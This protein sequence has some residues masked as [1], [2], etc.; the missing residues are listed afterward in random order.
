MDRFMTV[1]FPFKL[2]IGCDAGSDA[3]LLRYLALNHSLLSTGDSRHVRGPLPH[4]PIA[5]K[6]RGRTGEPI[7]PD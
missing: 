1:R 7:L 2:R 5:D 3:R 6:K 4:G